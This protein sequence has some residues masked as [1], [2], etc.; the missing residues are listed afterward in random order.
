MTTT[1]AND[2]DYFEIDVTEYAADAH[3]GFSSTASLSWDNMDWKITLGGWG[4]GRSV[5]RKKGVSGYLARVDHGTSDWKTMRSQMTVKVSDGEITV[6]RE[7]KKSFMTVKDDSIKKSDLKY[8]TVT[9]QWSSGTWKINAFPAGTVN[10]QKSSLQTFKRF[11][12]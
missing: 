2:F 1:N 10:Y 5:I 3:I 11:C 8:M 12:F 7:N 6:L 9:G 4:G